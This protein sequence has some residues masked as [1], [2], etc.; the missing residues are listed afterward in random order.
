MV[1]I[2]IT[3]HVLR[4]L[5]FSTFITIENNKVFFVLENNI[6]QHYIDR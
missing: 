3:E 5:I 6:I 1:K 2:N 4:K